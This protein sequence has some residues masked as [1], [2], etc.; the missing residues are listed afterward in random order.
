MVDENSLSQ[1]VSALRRTLGEASGDRCYI[2]T[3]PGVGYRVDAPE[4][5][6]EAGERQGTP[7]IAPATGAGASSPKSVT[8]ARA[9]DSHP[10]RR[11]S[12]PW[13]L[14]LPAVAGA[15][16]VALVVGVFATRGLLSAP[17]NARPQEQ[18][19]AVL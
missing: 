14:G 2:E 1:S 18:A 7:S 17:S 8:D 4:R 19:I 15:A 13:R 6:I 9:A 16:A 3:V 11:M 5:V 10:L 12:S